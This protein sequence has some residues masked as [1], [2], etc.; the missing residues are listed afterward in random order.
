MPVISILSQ[1][2]KDRQ[3]RMTEQEILY[4]PPLR[5][6]RLGERYSA[7][8]PTR[9][10]LSRGR[11]RTSRIRAA[12]CGRVNGF[13]SSTTSCLSRPLRVMASGA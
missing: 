12:S 4:V 9:Q 13:V 1:R 2:R 6:L 11:S 10:T 7:F 3:A 5:S 8:Q